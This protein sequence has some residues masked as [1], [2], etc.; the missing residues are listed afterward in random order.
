M[1]Y[2]LQLLLRDKSHRNLESVMFPIPLIIQKVKSLNDGCLS[3]HLL[4]I[5]SVAEFLSKGTN[6]LSSGTKS[7]IFAHNLRGYG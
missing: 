1:L 2:L 4:V 5:F 6:R 3:K 7:N